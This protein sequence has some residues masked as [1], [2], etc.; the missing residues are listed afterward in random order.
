MQGDFDLIRAGQLQTSIRPHPQD[1]IFWMVGTGARP[2][3]ILDLTWEQVDRRNNIIQLNPPQPR[4]D[5]DISS[6]GPHA[7]DLQPA[8]GHDIISGPVILYEGKMVAAIR[9]AWRKTRQRAGLDSQ[10]QPSP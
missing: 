9:T 2:D 10:V 4:A 5:E 3:T 8:V 6:F 7:K 1:A